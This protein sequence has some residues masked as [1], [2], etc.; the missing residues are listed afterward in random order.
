MLAQCAAMST[1][2]STTIQEQW[3]QNFSI[4][5]MLYLI[6]RRQTLTSVIILFT[7]STFQGLI[8]PVWDYIIILQ[9]STEK[10]LCV[11]RGHP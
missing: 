7:V 11:L 1:S 9:I 2:V 3:E 4:S 6:F 8:A 10:I 5:T